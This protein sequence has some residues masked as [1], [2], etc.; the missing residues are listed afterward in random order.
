MLYCDVCSVVYGNFGVTLKKEQM[1]LIQTTQ[2]E[3]NM[4]WKK[5]TKY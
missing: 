2:A 4:G 3:E 5:G 1:R